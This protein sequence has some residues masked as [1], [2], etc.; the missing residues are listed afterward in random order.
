M[1]LKIDN[2]V[3]IMVGKAAD[4]AAELFDGSSEEFYKAIGYSAL[5]SLLG[6]PDS[7]AYLIAAERLEHTTKHGW[8]LKRDEDYRDGQLVMAAQ[9]CVALYKNSPITARKLWPWRSGFGME[10]F[11]KIED[12]SKTD[13]LKIAGSFMAAEIDRIKALQP[14][15][16]AGL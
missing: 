7:G 2:S 8:D 15:E 13:Q 6:G 10:L 11:R 9:A 5:V 3:L 4:N 14:D 1:E 16:P 12:K